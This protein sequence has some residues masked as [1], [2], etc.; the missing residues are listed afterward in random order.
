MPPCSFPGCTVKYGEWVSSEDRLLRRCAK[1]REGG[2]IN[3]CK[4]HHACKYEGCDTI[5]SRALA[6]EKTAKYC[7]LHAPEGAMPPQLCHADGCN[8]IPS[9]GH[10]RAR[11]HCAKHREE[12]MILCGR[13]ICSID[14][15]LSRA[16]K[17]DYEGN[18]L[19]NKH[20]GDSKQL[21][22]F[23]ACHSIAT[24]TEKGYKRALY[25]SQHK[26]ETSSPYQK[27]LI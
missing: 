10:G 21:C 15:C 3:L 9:Y 18:R 7:R 1:H 12:G 4:S 22:V 20:A 14:G 2:M 19:C 5:A 8:T 23:D 6:G 16:V 13:S 26:K 17:K 24:W 25:C 27:N 11:T